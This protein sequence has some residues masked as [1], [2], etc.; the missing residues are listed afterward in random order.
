M[1]FN[2]SHQLYFSLLFQI[3]TPSSA[4]S[5]NQATYAHLYYSCYSVQFV[6]LTIGYCF[7]PTNMYHISD[8]TAYFS[9]WYTVKVTILYRQSRHAGVLKEIDKLDFF[10]FCFLN[11]SLYAFSPYHVWLSRN[12]A[13]V[14]CL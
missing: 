8:T 14:P 11:G 1:R 5:E 2:G 12:R 4:I 9:D 7:N 10:I 6:T 13:G 3:R